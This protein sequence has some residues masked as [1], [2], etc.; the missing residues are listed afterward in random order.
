[1]FNVSDFATKISDAGLAKSSRF[2]MRINAPSFPEHFINKYGKYLGINN[3]DLYCNSLNL[4]GKSFVNSDIR[5]FGYGN[6]E[7]R[8]HNVSYSELTAD[9]YL[10]MKGSQL[11]F[12]NA[13]MDYILG[14][15][16]IP[17]AVTGFSE[18]AQESYSH[19]VAYPNTYLTTV[20]IYLLREDVNPKRQQDLSD[21][22]VRH[23]KIHDAFPSTIGDV[24]LAWQNQNTLMRFP[25]TFQY[26][27][28]EDVNVAYKYQYKGV[29]YVHPHQEQIDSFIDNEQRIGRQEAL[30]NAD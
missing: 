30:K 18:Q 29:S 21:I 16:D 7:R 15:K 23:Y 17:G 24:D 6:I 12:F 1:M 14:V 4:P 11:N 5:R 25:V 10:D 22:S 19:E 9:F 8:P 26:K 20:D 27:T 13:W 2:L 3:L 28:F